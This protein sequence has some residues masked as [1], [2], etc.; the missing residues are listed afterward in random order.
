M[1]IYNKYKISNYL[2]LKE[3]LD[4]ISEEILNQQF[5]DYIFNY[6]K[7][8][9]RNFLFFFFITYSLETFSY[10]YFKINPIYHLRVNTTILTII[11]NNCTDNF[12]NFCFK[13]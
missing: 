11:D 8:L 4:L 13:K 5:V 2:N 7:K 9:I 3:S 1:L 12:Y 6:K 10:F